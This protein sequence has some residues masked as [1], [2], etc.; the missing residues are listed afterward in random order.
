WHSDPIATDRHSPGNPGL[1]RAR[2]PGSSLPRRRESSGLAAAAGS[3]LP[4]C[5]RAV[6]AAVLLLQVRSVLR[7]L[8]VQAAAVLTAD[9][10]QRQALLSGSGESAAAG[11]ASLRAWMLTS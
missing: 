7:T 8:F 3:K 10:R 2:L 4:A 11:S 5:R 9:C 1:L 6:A